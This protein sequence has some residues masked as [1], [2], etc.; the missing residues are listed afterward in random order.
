MIRQVK[1]VHQKRGLRR[2]LLF[3][4]LIPL[5]LMIFLSTHFAFGQSGSSGMITGLITDAN[6]GVALPGANVMIEGTS[7]GAASNADGV[8]TIAKVPPGTYTIVVTYIGFQKEEASVKVTQTGTTEQNFELNFVSVEGEAVMVTAQAAGQLQA[9]ND[10]LSSNTIKNVVSSEKIH[11][12]P[13]ADAATALS[14]LPGVSLMNGDQIVIRGVQAKLNQVLLNGVQLPSTDMNNRATNLGFISSNLLSGIEVIKAITPD[15]DANTIGGVVNLKLREAPN[16]FH[17]DALAQG[18]YN[19][20]DHVSDNYTF[21]SS[22]SNRFIGDKLGVFVQANMDRT[23]GGNQ[24]ANIGPTLIAESN[25]EFGEGTY[26]TNTANFG[27]GANLVKNSGGS[28]ILDYRL[29]NGKIILQ[30]TYAGNLTDQNNNQIQMNYDQ[31]QISYTV[32]RRLYEKDLL[33][34]ALQSE[35]TFGIT[36]VQTSFSHSFTK[37]KT[38]YGHRPNPWTLFQSPGTVAP[39]GTDASGQPIVYTGDVQ[40]KITLKS[41]LGILDNLNP[42]DAEL[43]QLSGWVSERYDDFNQHLYNASMDVST[44]FNLSSKLNAEIKAGGKITKT[45][46]KNDV[47]VYFAHGN[48]DW[49]ADSTA[50]AYF[51][52]PTL[53]DAR[54][55]KLTRVMTS[56]DRGKYYMDSFYDF[57]NGGYKYFIDP[58]KYDPWLKLSRNGWAYPLKDSDS[59]Q[60]DWDGSEQFSAGYL[61][62]TLNYGQD[63]TLFGGVRFESYNMDYHAQFTHVQHNVFG[64]AVS[65]RNGSVIDDDNPPPDSLYHRVPYNSHNVDRTDNNIFPNVQLRYHVNNWSD[66]RLA[67]TTGIARPD[68]SAII[69]KVSFENGSFTL[70]N[71]KLRPSTA[72]NFDVIASFYSNHIGLFTLDAFYKEIEDQMYN[73]SIYLANRDEYAANVYIPDSTLLDDGFGVLA[74]PNYRINVSLNNQ[75]KGFI[76]GVELDWQTNFWYLPGILSS[77]VLD[78]NYTKSTSK[79]QYTVLTPTVSTVNDT[80]NGR[81]RP[82]NVYSTVKTVYKGR[83]IQQANDV[84]N[85]AVGSDYKGFHTRLSFSMTGNIINSIGTRPEEASFTGNIYRWDFTVKQELPLDGLSLTLNGRNIFHQGIKTYRKYRRDQDAPITENLVSILYFPSVFSMNLRYSF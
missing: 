74:L 76:R 80:V 10:Q 20:Q 28:L 7:L 27:Y 52:E 70:G 49:Y 8:Y 22:V 32:D 73:T 36:K 40:K 35:N 26:K 13:D 23:D 37:Q 51:G 24:T 2:K 45:T 53:S 69:P 57:K 67:Y 58:D 50:N 59:W 11:Q 65:T 77:L 81:I 19:A 39:F 83:L 82:R 25:V 64:T 85:V 56:F 63:L 30:N 18:D 42:E 62:G 38:K 15:M 54:P 75:D 6:S 84:V 21:W 44:P 9:I 46:R 16:D 31:S 12:L 1:P 71:P 48:P 78:V 14:R 60:D 47:D 55:L 34:N 79:T 4:G 29:P 68:Y 33:I 61:M 41:A 66:L 17:F 3:R 43:A 5:L 72:Q